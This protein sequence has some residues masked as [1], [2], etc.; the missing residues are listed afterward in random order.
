MRHDDG[1]PRFAYV[2]LLTL[3]DSYLP[4]VLLLAYGLRRQQTEAD[5]ICLV[6]P[7]ITDG[8]RQAINL[9]YDHVL[10][11]PTIYIPHSRSGKRPYLPYV[12]SKLHALRLGEDGDLS[13]HYDKIVLLDADLLP[14]KHF[15][16]LFTLPAPAGSINE[17]KTHVMQWGEDGNFII[18]DSVW[19]N[20]TWNWHEIYADYAHGQPIP[21]EVTDRVL[22]DPNNMGVISSLLVL[23]P[24]LAEFEAIMQDI[25]QPASRQLVS[26]TFAWPEMQY[27]TQRWSGQWTNVDIRYHSLN[28]YPDI[29]VLFGLHFTGF[30]PWQFR[31]EGSMAR[32]GRRADF[33]YW[34]Q[35][36]R[37]MLGTY[38]DLKSFKKLAHL[39]AQI[40]AFQG[41][42]K[43]PNTPPKKRKP[44]S[45]GPRSRK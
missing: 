28:G 36:Y 19:Q 41:K 20:G 45:R 1:R 8:A 34:H 4:A 32:Y 27:M 31:K 22:A 35:R 21:A 11:V 43:P 15:D 25:E 18:P 24:D 33:Q 2:T 40:D 29:S 37:Q 5:L 38:P 7:E 30:K 17:H 13:L 3:N 26:D 10:T 9:L 14:I 6:T 42:S 12:F 23:Q 39:L 44:R 16:H